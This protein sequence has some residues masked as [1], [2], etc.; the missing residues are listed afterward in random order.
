VPRRQSLTFVSTTP[1]TRSRNF[2]CDVV[3][4]YLRADVAADGPW[5][6]DDARHPESQAGRQTAAGSAGVGRLDDELVGRPLRRAGRQDVVEQVVVLVVAE[7]EDGLGPH[8]GVGRDG[9]D[10][11]G[12]DLGSG[13]RQRG[14]VLVETRGRHDPAHGRQR[15]VEAVVL[16]LASGCTVMPKSTIG[17]P[18]WA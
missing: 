12:H 5:R 16:E 9:V 1:V 15:V 11:A 2:S 17:W 4:G 10:L 6:H 8:V 13:R 18:G 7:D 14:G 3:L